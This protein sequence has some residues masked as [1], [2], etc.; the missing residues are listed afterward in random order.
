MPESNMYG[1]VGRKE[2]QLAKR[3]FTQLNVRTGDVDW[4]GHSNPRLVIVYISALAHS[5]GIADH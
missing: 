1:V 2:A 4:I 5:Y 3:C